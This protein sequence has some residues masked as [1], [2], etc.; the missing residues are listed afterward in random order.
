MEPV[1]NSKVIRTSVSTSVTKEEIL[2]W[3][4]DVRPMYR[5]ALNFANMDEMTDDAA[6]KA[7][8]TLTEQLM[9]LYKMQSPTKLENLH[10]QLSQVLLDVIASYSSHFIRDDQRS[11]K[12]RRRALHGIRAFQKSLNSVGI[13]TR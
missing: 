11:E 8:N 4:Q 1:H 6:L 3:W 2:Q 5:H 9:Q 13:R 12:D 10:A 7:Y